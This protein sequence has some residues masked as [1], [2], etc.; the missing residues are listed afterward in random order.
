MIMMIPKVTKPEEGDNRG[1]LKAM[2]ERKKGSSVMMRKK[3]RHAVIMWLT[4]S[5]KKNFEMTKVLTSM[6]ELATMT[7][8]R[9]IMF[10]TRITLRTM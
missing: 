9:P 3:L 10:M 4:A 6:T 5:K 8:M 1:Q 2:Y 7:A